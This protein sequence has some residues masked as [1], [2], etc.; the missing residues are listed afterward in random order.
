[1]LHKGS[2]ADEI[3]Q[4]LICHA[5]GKGLDG[6]EG[7]CLCVEFVRLLVPVELVPQLILV[8]PEVDSNPHQR[9]RYVRNG[10]H[11]FG[12]T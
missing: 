3:P 2:H 10:S 5:Q 4:H 6:F 9:V 12:L 8:V 7:P 1:M 11:G